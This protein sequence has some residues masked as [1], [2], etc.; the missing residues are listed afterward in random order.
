[1]PSHAFKSS[2]DLSQLVQIGARALQHNTPPFDGRTAS[3]GSEAGSWSSEKTLVGEDPT[4]GPSGGNQMET[5]STPVYTEEPGG[6]SGVNRGRHYSG[7]KAYDQASQIN[8]NAG[9]IPSESAYGYSSWVNISASGRSN[10]W[11]GDI[12]DATVLAGFFSPRGR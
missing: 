1:M 5:N 7:I 6:C 8:G 10:Q 4:M 11:N 2:A 9:F 3:A 12:M